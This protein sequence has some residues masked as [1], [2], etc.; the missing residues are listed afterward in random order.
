M[1]IVMNR[2]FSKVGNVNGYLRNQ[3]LVI[4]PPMESESAA[5]FG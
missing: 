5:F 4:R 2:S 1:S 3:P